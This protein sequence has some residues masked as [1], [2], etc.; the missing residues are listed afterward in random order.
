M[1]LFD[2]LGPWLYPLAGVGLC[3]LAAV[4]R[5][6]VMVA[7]MEGRLPASGPPHHAV[8]AWGVLGGVV[9]LLGTV[10]GFGR[11]ALG[12]RAATGAERAELEAMFAVLWDGALVIATPVTV[13]LWLFT[14]AL[15]CW[16]GLYYW[17]EA[18]LGSQ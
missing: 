15:V 16:L 6:V 5:A 9:G 7:R 3:L 10:V 17:I 1:Q 4:V 14:T 2:M 8:L 12:V 18:R 11:M 13:G